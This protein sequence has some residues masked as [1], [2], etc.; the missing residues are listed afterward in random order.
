M[1][2]NKLSNWRVTTDKFEITYPHEAYDDELPFRVATI[3]SYP[4][5]GRAYQLMYLSEELITL[6]E[7]EIINILSQWMQDGI[8]CRI[9]MGD[10]KE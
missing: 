7:E 1:D 6:S 3:H 8:D 5:Q 4:G 2:K 9:S 10:I